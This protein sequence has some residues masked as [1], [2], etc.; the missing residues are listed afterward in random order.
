MSRGFHVLVGVS[1]DEGFPL[2]GE[3]EGEEVGGGGGGGGG[4]GRGEEE[5]AGEDQGDERE[6]L[7]GQAV[8]VEFEPKFSGFEGVMQLCH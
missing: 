3:G 5:E 2:G 8:E 7:L 6:E 4:G 1:S